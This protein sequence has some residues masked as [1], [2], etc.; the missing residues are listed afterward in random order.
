MRCSAPALSAVHP[1]V[2]STPPRVFTR[3][4]LVTPAN[5]PSSPAG[6]ARYSAHGRLSPPAFC[7]ARGKP[8]TLLRSPVDSHRLG[9]VWRATLRAPSY[10]V[11][12]GA[13]KLQA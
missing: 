13:T 9:E 4:M 1:E 10:N 7:A 8:E 3:W 5:M 12:S 2:G 6:R 11:A